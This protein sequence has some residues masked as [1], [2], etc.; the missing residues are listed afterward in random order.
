[1]VGNCDR[2]HNEFRST[3]LV[4]CNRYRPCVEYTAFLTG[5]GTDYRPNW[6]FMIF[7]LLFTNFLQWVV[8]R[9]PRLRQKVLSFARSSPADRT[10]LCYRFVIHGCRT[11][12]QFV[13]GRCRASVNGLPEQNVLLPYICVPALLAWGPRRRRRREEYGVG[14]RCLIPT[15]RGVWRDGCAPTP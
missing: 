2:W 10:N 12:L 13:H 8:D 6:S 7:S 5:S 14:R 9:Q 3:R 11:D 15:R 4:R 1:M